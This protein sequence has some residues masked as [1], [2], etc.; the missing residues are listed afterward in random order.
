[1]YL[2]CPGSRQNLV[3]CSTG[4]GR[5]TALTVAARMRPAGNIAK[6]A[7]D[8]FDRGL[9]NGRSRRILVIAD[10]CGEGPFI[11]PLQTFVIERRITVGSPLHYSDHVIGQCPGFLRES[12][13]DACRGHRLETVDA[14]YTPGTISHPQS[15]SPSFHRH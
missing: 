15:R 6:A 13:C 14:P 7:F 2:S 12:L 4:L 8:G 3:G 9:W 11:Y 10:R 5:V 1:V